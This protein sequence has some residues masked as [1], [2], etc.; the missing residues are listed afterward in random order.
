MGLMKHCDSRQLS[1]GLL[2]P[3]TGG[4]LGDGAIQEAVI[5][6]LRA[7]FPGCRLQAFTLD[8]VNTER[9]HQIP[10]APLTALSVP[11]YRVNTAPAPADAPKPMADEPMAVQRL[12]EAVKKIAPLYRLAQFA[13]QVAKVAACLSAEARF[14]RD[15]YRTLK[16]L[17]LLIVS[18]GGQLDDYWG[19]PWG[20]PFS[21]L[22]W[23]VLARL[24]NT[25]YLFLSV[26]TCAI[27]SR[28]SFHFVKWALRLADYRSY[29]DARS[30]QRL[31]KMAFTGGDPVCPDLAFSLEIPRRS[32]SSVGA[33]GRPV[34]GVSPIAY[35]SSHSW[36]K[37]DLGTYEPYI[38]TLKSFVASL[39]AEGT[40]VILYFTDSTDKVVVRELAGELQSFAADSPGTLAVQPTETVAELLQLMGRVDYVVASRL[41]GVILAHLMDRPVVA[42]SYDTKVDTHMNELGQQEYCLDI[43][44]LELA[45]LC[46]AYAA[47][48]GESQAARTRISAQAAKYR[49]L[50]AAQY[51]GLLNYSGARVLTPA[52]A[53][54]RRCQ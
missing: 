12:K 29:R 35:L 41:H 16:G 27:E 37:S 36:P 43:H 14:L 6:N 15:G 50:L 34:V 47:L 28:L 51:D 3:Y 9:L 5:A 45:A 40:T 32:V 38:A 7:R 11:H 31:E 17:D 48:R 20:H 18:G 2:T 53:M 1:I 24:A 25:P 39:L 10:C 44:R 42:I 21:L 49:S 54:S 8:P 33:G 26:G 52:R 4:N 30:K 13:R 22:K 19:G 46:R 23:G